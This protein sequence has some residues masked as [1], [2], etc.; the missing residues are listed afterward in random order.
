MKKVYHQPTVRV[1]ELTPSTA[2]LSGSLGNGIF[3]SP[4]N[5]ELGGE[6]DFA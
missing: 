6:D 3:E 4:L 5:D 1:Q 2:L